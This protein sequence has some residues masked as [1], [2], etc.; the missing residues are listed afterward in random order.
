MPQPWRNLRSIELGPATDLIERD[1]SQELFHCAAACVLRC[2]LVVLL[3]RSCLLYIALILSTEQCHT[4]MCHA[5]QVAEL[6]RS[7]AG[8]HPG[9]V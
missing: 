6:E 2:D 4:A 8:T 5:V 7:A 1:V 3:K 9:I